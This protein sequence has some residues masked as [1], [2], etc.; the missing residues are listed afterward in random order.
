MP[1]FVTPARRKINSPAKRMIIHT[2]EKKSAWWKVFFFY[3]WKWIVWSIIA[4]TLV[5]FVFYYNRSP[6]QRVV[7]DQSTQETMAYQDAFE[8]IQTALI[9]KSYYKEKNF[10]RTDLEETIRAK[11]PIIAHISHVS[12]NNGTL[13]LALEYHQPDFLMSTENSVEWLVY[14]N[15][16]IPNTSWTN[17]GST[18][19]RIHIVLPEDVFL[20]YSWGVF[21][22]S[23][24]QHIAQTIKQIDFIT[25][26]SSITYYP[27]REKLSLEDKK[28]TFIIGLDPS[29]LEITFS[30]RKKIMPYLPTAIPAKVDLSNPSHIIIQH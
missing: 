10:H 26:F 19:I 22:G 8:D 14:K 1:V 23:S 27:G 12:F 2:A 6:I 28:N 7:F 13:T 15:S 17:L 18:G 25:W 30:Q 20:T 5:Y 16:I 4:A 3:Y 24:S 11:Y 29:K 9:N 21:W